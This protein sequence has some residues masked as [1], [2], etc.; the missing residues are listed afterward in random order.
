MWILALPL[1][2]HGFAFFRSTFKGPESKLAWRLQSFLSCVMSTSRSGRANLLK[3]SIFSHQ[4]IFDL[5]WS[6]DLFDC[7]ASFV[8]ALLELTSMKLEQ[9]MF[10]MIPIRNPWKPLWAVV[11]TQ[12]FWFS[13]GILLRGMPWVKTRMKWRIQEDSGRVFVSAHSWDARPE[14]RLPG[15]M[16]TGGKCR[17]YQLDLY[18][19]SDFVTHSASVCS[20]H[21]ESCQQ[22]SRFTATA[23][24]LNVGAYCL[25]W[26]SMTIAKEISI[27]T[28]R[29][30]RMCSWSPDS[31]DFELSSGFTPGGW[32]V[33]IPASTTL[34]NPPT[35]GRS[36]SLVIASFDLLLSATNWG[37]SCW[38]SS[39]DH[40]LL[41][42]T[43]PYTSPTT[44]NRHCH[45][46]SSNHPQW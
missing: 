23:F 6:T 37:H 30:K 32:L 5:F 14:A 8:V 34:E 38:I 17:S 24:D 13:Y 39:T 20:D 46:E 19:H 2:C 16:K 1:K 25:D 35:A 40:W 12:L 29:E 27:S 44:M 7:S 28:Q 9:E 33:R 3:Q 43:L 4:I 42:T 36:F 21:R 45:P 15:A 10:Q 18:L 22:M 26:A 41:L 11:K 31:A